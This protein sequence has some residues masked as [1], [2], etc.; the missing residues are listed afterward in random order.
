[1][2]KGGEMDER[3]LRER[4]VAVVFRKGKVLLVKDKNLVKYSLP[5]GG[6]Q[7]GETLAQ[8]AARELY[9]ETGLTARKIHYIGSFKGAVSHHQAFLVEATEQP[10]LKNTD[11]Q[12]GGEL[13]SIVWWDMKSPLPVYQHVKVILGLLKKR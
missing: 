9:E 6:L 12:G 3:E 1:M 10:Y 8:A 5:G 2:G 7:D 13:S 11:E 4:A